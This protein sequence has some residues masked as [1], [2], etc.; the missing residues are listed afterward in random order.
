M[1]KVVSIA[2][3]NHEIAIQ[4]VPIFVSIYEFIVVPFNTSRRIKCFI[5]TFFSVDEHNFNAAYAKCT[6]MKK[7]TKSMKCLLLF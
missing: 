6:A 2:V 5:F 4:F 3:I 1:T 7:S